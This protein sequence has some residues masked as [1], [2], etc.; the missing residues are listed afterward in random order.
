MSGGGDV[1]VQFRD[2]RIELE[3]V[4]IPMRIVKHGK[5]ATIEA[6]AEMPTLTTTD[7]RSVLDRVRR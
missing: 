1:E 6:D 3:P 2:G 7:V 4:A 5:A